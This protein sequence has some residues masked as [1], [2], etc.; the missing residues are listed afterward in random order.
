MLDQCIILTAAIVKCESFSVI[1][2]SI[3]IKYAIK[4]SNFSDSLSTKWPKVTVGIAVRC[5]AFL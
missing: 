4:H 3:P 5:F 2:H 1:L